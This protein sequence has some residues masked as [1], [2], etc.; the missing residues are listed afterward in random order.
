VGGN[1]RSFGK[2]DRGRGLL[3]DNPHEVEMLK[4]KNGR[5]LLSIILKYRH[6]LYYTALNRRMSDK[7]VESNCDLV[8]V[9]L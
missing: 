2:T 3:L 6:F 1:R 8:K 5:L 4:E 9:L 7:L